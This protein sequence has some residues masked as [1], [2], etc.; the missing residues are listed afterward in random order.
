MLHESRDGFRHDRFKPLLRFGFM[1]LLVPILVL[2]HDFPQILDQGRSISPLFAIGRHG[3][4]GLAHP[5]ASMLRPSRGL[6]RFGLIT[7]FITGVAA[8]MIQRT[9]I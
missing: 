2:E 8:C 3:F 6:M 5:R 9:P 7:S 1:G 4:E